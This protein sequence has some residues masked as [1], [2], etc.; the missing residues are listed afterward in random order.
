MCFTTDI[1]YSYVVIDINSVIYKYKYKLTY[2]H[3]FKIFHKIRRTKVELP[4]K[5]IPHCIK[6]VSHELWNVRN[7][8]LQFTVL[9]PVWKDFTK[10]IAAI[11]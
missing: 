4:V 11:H 1:T 5:L 3:M 8:V 7:D 10:Q 2:Y 6:N 9:V